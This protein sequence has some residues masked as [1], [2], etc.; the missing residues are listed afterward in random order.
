[1]ER[2]RRSGK[3]AAAAV[4]TEHCHIH[5]NSLDLAAH[6]AMD[7]MTHT[8]NSKE[9]VGRHQ[10]VGIHSLSAVYLVEALVGEEDLLTS[11][12]SKTTAVR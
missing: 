1:M 9:L 3:A 10:T 7:H 11:L 2:I 8:L 4:D 12:H 5:Q 6:S